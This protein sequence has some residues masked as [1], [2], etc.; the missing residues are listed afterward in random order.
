VSL[1]ALC[2]LYRQ[3]QP[4]QL[5][6]SFIVVGHINGTEVESADSI[7]V[8]GSP[9]DLQSWHFVGLREGFE[10]KF[11]WGRPCFQNSNFNQPI[12]SHKNSQL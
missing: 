2:T 12:N 10:T 9:F 8:S 11:S 7:D 1:S 6:R 3:H 5:L 4:N